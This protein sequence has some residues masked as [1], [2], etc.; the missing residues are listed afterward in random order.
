MKGKILKYSFILA[1]CFAFAFCFMPKQSLAANNDWIYDKDAQTL[2]N[3]DG[4]ALINVTANGNELTLGNNQTI[5]FNVSSIDLTGTIKDIDGKEY[6]ITSLG[7]RT[8]YD[9]YTLKDIKLPETLISIDEQAFCWCSGLE[10]ITIPNSV[11]SIGD[12]AFSWCSGLKNIYFLS[13]TP[14]N[15]GVDLFDHNPD[16]I[17]VPSSSIDAYKMANGWSNYTNIIQS[18]IYKVTVENGSGG[19][20]FIEGET[21]NIK[22]NDNNEKGHFTSWKVTSGNVTLA[23]EK[24]K[25]TTFTMVGSDITIEAVFEAHNY[26]DGKCSICGYED[27]NYVPP[28]D[29]NKENDGNNDKNNNSVSSNSQ[30]NTNNTSQ[31][32]IVKT[33]DNNNLIIWCL[34]VGVCVLSIGSLIV[35]KKRTN[36]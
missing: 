30:I 28:K 4:T 27:K 2:T 10:E 31:N 26:V 21:I 1:I 19:G 5:S 6:I 35:Y 20:N 29:D 7:F 16:A 14:P 8:F 25:E 24:A 22:A 34:V 32:G 9:K 11:M 13:E 36:K 3:E 12:Y 15:I 33:G 17:Y 23:D 18:G